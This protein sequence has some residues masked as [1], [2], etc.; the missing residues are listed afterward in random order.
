VIISHCKVASEYCEGVAS[1][2]SREPVH[3]Q[4]P[5]IQNMFAQIAKRNQKVKLNMEAQAESL[6]APEQ[7]RLLSTMDLER[8]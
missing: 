2:S 3:D 5:L 4:V 6:V 1:P 7:T 8:R